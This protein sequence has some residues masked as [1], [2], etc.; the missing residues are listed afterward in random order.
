MLNERPLIKTTNTPLL[1]GD[2]ATSSPATGSAEDATPLTDMAR[3]PHDSITLVAMCRQLEW[4]NAELRK[5]LHAAIDSSTLLEKLDELKSIYDMKAKESEERT[6]K[7]VAESQSLAVVNCIIIA[8]GL[9]LEK[10]S[11]D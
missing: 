7:V 5:G 11:N 8:Q 4:E 9:L 1:F 2:T 3:R 10:L 6:A